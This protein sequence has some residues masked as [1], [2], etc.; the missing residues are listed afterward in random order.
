M[1]IIPAYNEEST[2]GA[3][4][5]KVKPFVDRVYVIDDAST[6]ATASMAEEAG[7]IVI[8]HEVNQG[9]ASALNSGYRAA[10]ED[11]ARVVVQLDADGQHDPGHLP[12]LVDALDEQTEIVIA[13]RFLDGSETSYSFVRKWGIRFFS[14]LTSVFGGTRISDVTSGYRIYRVSALSRIPPSP[15]RH[16]AVE[17]TLIALRLG[18][19]IK[20]VSVTIPPRLQG[21]SQFRLGVAALY[22]IRMTS[23]ILRA[24]RISRGL[25]TRSRMS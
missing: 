10:T 16:W 17:Q 20:E 19:R 7:A 4:V 12:T 8:R 23:A 18:L 9:I 24:L 1:A 11:N 13:S 14:F 5:A 22:P 15:G 21:E 3:V 2:T 25:R 6:D